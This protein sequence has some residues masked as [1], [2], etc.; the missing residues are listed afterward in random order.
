MIPIYHYEINGNLIEET[1]ENFQSHFSSEKIWQNDVYIQ[2]ETSPRF[3]FSEAIARKQFKERL[4]NAKRLNILR[5]KM[6]QKENHSI[7]EL[8]IEFE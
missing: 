1:L 8:L 6:L 7:D 5:M 4:M 3:F 2:S